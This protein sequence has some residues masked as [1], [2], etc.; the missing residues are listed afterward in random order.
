[1]LLACMLCTLMFACS[2]R[3]YGTIPAGTVSETLWCATWNDW[4]AGSVSGNNPYKHCSSSGTGLMADHLA[5]YKTTR[6]PCAA[7]GSLPYSNEV[8]EST[9]TRFAWATY[10]S[11]CPGSAGHYLQSDIHAGGGSVPEAHAVP[12]CTG[13]SYPLGESCYCPAGYQPGSA[14]EGC[15]VISNCR[16]RVRDKFWG[17]VGGVSKALYPMATETRSLVQCYQGCEVVGDMASESGGQSYLWNPQATGKTCEGNKP[18]TSPGA[19]PSDHDGSTGDKAPDQ[20][21]KGQCPGTVNGASVVVPCGTSDTGRTQ[22]KSNSDGTSTETQ[23]TT[24]CDASG[25]VTTTTTTNKDSSGNVTG[26]STNVSYGADTQDPNRPGGSGRS[27]SGGSGT[28]T[29]TDCGSGGESEWAGTCEAGFT[30]SGDAVQ[31]AMAR[32]Q[33]TRHCTAFEGENAATAAY[34]AAS[35]AGVHPSD[36]PYTTG[37]TSAVDFATGL[38]QSDALGAGAC[39]APQ[40][41]AFGSFSY[42]VSFTNLCTPLG[43]LGNVLVALSLLSSVFIVFGRKEG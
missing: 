41:I 29:G 38:D 3:A 4:S 2:A 31:C 20:L 35:A 15:V 5:W 9:S 36:H 26:T 43:W 27:G 39:P 25:C 11:G 34:A 30:C 18:G 13:N 7:D 14:G 33:F 12:G 16:D 8:T 24:S 28:C 19:T 42:T 37:T 6:V 10:S 23:K 1:M 32:D 22:T 40:T 21:P 17:D